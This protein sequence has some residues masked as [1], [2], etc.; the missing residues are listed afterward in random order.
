MN[1]CS[2][3]LGK[4]SQG[5]D[6]IT[7]RIKPSLHRL[8]LLTCMS[9]LKLFLGGREHAWKDAENH[10]HA[11][12]TETPAF[13]SQAV[14]AL[15]K[16][17]GKICEEKER[18]ERRHKAKDKNQLLYK[19][20]TLHQKISNTGFGYGRSQHH[21]TYK[22]KRRDSKYSKHNDRAAVHSKRKDPETQRS[23][24]YV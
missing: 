10:K 18:N 3:D 15:K 20:A 13:A 17:K 23:K 9:M 11:L 12:P 22:C 14:K 2:L 16:C 6:R 1:S 8:A 21:F 4:D 7:Y 24:G 19:T 5:A